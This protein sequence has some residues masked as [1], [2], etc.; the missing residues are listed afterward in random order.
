MTKA[1][2][3][4]YFE[5]T[6]N[7]KTDKYNITSTNLK[8]EKKVF[9]EV[10]ENYLYAQMGAGEDKSPSAKLEEYKIKI[11]LDLS[12]DIFYTESNTGN[13]GLTTGIV[14]GFSKS[15]ESILKVANY[16]TQS[17][18]VANYNAQSDILK[19]TIDIFLKENP[20]IPETEITIIEKNIGS[21]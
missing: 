11:G 19:H 17:V 13:K 15:L 4:V 8:K 18:K 10:I 20:N 6:W 21:S 9:E 1:A 12:E 5:F 2:V 7:P 16:N 3:D 14:M